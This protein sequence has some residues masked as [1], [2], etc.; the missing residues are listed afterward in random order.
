MDNAPRK[1]LE[2]LT[3]NIKSC[4]TISKTKHENILKFYGAWVSRGL[5]NARGEINMGFEFAQNG[6]LDDYLR[7]SRRSD[8]GSRMSTMTSFEILKILFGIANG[9]SGLH[10]INVVHGNLKGENTFFTLNI[11][12]IYFFLS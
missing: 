12:I 5:G 11:F 4:E 1:Q 2:G 10:N 9:L 8:P 7:Q 6:S 3:E